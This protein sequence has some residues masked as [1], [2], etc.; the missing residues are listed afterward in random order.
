[1]LYNIHNLRMSLIRW[2]F[3]NKFKAIKIIIIHC[4]ITETNLYAGAMYKD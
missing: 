2:S 4:A 1:M 3:N